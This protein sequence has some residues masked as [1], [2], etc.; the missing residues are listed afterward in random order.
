L[1]DLTLSQMQLVQSEKMAAIGQLVAGVAHEINNNINFI[2]G[3]LPLLGRLTSELTNR[4]VTLE[5]KSGIE[6]DRT[7]QISQEISYLIKN[8]AEGVTRTTRI[9]KDL[10]AFSRPS[11]GHFLPTNIHEEIERTLALLEFQFNNGIVIHKDFAADMACIFC[12]REEMNQ[13][14][15]NILLNAV[16]AMHGRGDIWISTWRDEKDVHIS[17]R[18]NGP[19][20]P[21]AL[22]T[23]IFD[24][25]FT[26]KQ[27]GEGTGLGLSIVYGIVSSHQGEIHATSTV[28]E[29]SEFVISLP[30]EE[31]RPAKR[32]YS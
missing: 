19:G 14:Y 17:F 10:N 6:E 26:T 11:Q 3:S 16:S 12:L 29:G 32:Q 28:G 23:K 1:D 31:P 13:V 20:M 18:D 27:V 30:I 15:M 9:V 8:A 24:P 2:S 22:L 4:L 5:A 7:G 25:F 21:E